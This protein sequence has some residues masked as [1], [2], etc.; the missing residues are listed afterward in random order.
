MQKKLVILKVSLSLSLR[1]KT[2]FI[3]QTGYVHAHQNTEKK[4]ALMRA[5]NSSNLYEGKKHT[6]HNDL[7][8]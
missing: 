8:F 5:L 2:T 1:V 7:L 3:Y 6:Q 4:A